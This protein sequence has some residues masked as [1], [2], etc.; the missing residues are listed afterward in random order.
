MIP[1]DVLM[2]LPWGFH[3]TDVFPWHS[4]GI[5]EFSWQPCGTLIHLQ[6]DVHAILVSLVLWVFHILFEPLINIPIVKL[7]CISCCRLD[8]AVIIHESQLSFEEEVSIMSRDLD[9]CSTSWYVGFYV[10]SVCPEV[11]P[12]RVYICLLYTS[13]AADE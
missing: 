11:Y 6:W 4:H 1:L 5:R 2:E 3:G 9:Q 10:S 8:E 7:R 12:Y 13:D